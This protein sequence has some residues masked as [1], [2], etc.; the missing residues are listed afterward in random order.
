MNAEATDNKALAKREPQ[1]LNLSNGIFFEPAA[2][3]TALQ[4]AKGLAASDM[5][6]AAFKGKPGNVLIALDFAARAK[7]SPLAVMHGMYRVHG[8]PSFEGQ[9]VIGLAKAG[10][11]TLS[12]SDRSGKISGVWN[13]RETPS[14]L[15]S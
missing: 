5:V 4:V 15:I 2:F 13:T 11:M 3:E 14:W 1:A 12:S 10:I 8:N 9:F 6:P 7:I